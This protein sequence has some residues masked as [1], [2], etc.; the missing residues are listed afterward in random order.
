[1]VV[2]EQLLY[3]LLFDFSFL[4]FDQQEWI[5][6][7]LRMDFFCKTKQICPPIGKSLRRESE[8]RQRSELFFYDKKFFGEAELQSHPLH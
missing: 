6:R 5:E 1:M 2:T 3:R 7:I 8:V 4:A